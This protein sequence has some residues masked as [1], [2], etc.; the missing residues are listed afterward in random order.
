MTYNNNSSNKTLYLRTFYVLYI[1]PNDNGTN[2]LIS[3]LST[4]QLL[5]TPKYK[6]VPMPEDLIETISKMV[7]FTN[8]IQTIHFDRDQHTAQQDYFGTTQDDNQEQYVSIYIYIYIY[9][10]I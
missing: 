1:R 10:Y 4:R 8:N 5:T 3:E 7:T 6:P 2:H 9:I